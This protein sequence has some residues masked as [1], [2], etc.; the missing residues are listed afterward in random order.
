M[1]QAAILK[2]GEVVKLT[3]LINPK[4]TI[5][6]FLNSFE[7]V[8]NG[9]T[10]IYKETLKEDFRDDD[11]FGQ[12]DK[13]VIGG[14]YEQDFFLEYLTDKNKLNQLKDHKYPF[15]S[16]SVNDEIIVK[17]LKVLSP[18]TDFCKIETYKWTYQPNIPIVDYGTWQIKI[19]N[20][21]FPNPPE[22]VNTQLNPTAMQFYSHKIGLFVTPLTDQNDKQAKAFLFAKIGIL[23]NSIERI[24]NLIE[25]DTNS[26]FGQYINSQKSEWSTQPIFTNPTVAVLEDYMRILTNFYNSFYINQI[27]IKKAPNKEKFY[28]LARCLSAEALS[29]VPTNDKIELL[30]NISGFSH[31]LTESNNG[32]QLA[33]KIIESFTFNSVTAAER[34]DLLYALMQIQVYQVPNSYKKT[35][36]FDTKQTLFE[37]L[38]S[39]IDDDRISRYTVGP[40]EYIAG[41]LKTNDNRKK[42]IL[43][44]Y[45]I[46][47]SSMYNPKYADPS[48]SSP[49]NIFGI[50]PESYYMK[51]IPENDNSSS[52]SAFYN[53]ETSPAILVYNA[54]TSSSTDHYMRTTGVE[55]ILGDLEGKK[56]KIHQKQT[57]SIIENSSKENNQHISTFTSL[58]GTYDLYQPISIIGFRP[59]LDLVETFEDPETGVNLNDPFPNIPVFF[60]YYMQDYSD[61]KKLDFGIVLVAE[62]AL[63]LTG[64]G[65]LN[66]LKY[67]GYLSKARSVWTGT[68]TASETVLFW[69]AVEGVNATVQFTA[70]N[71]SAI[72]NYSNNT[73]TDPDIKEFTNK[74]SVLFDI[75]TIVSLGTDP[76]MKKKLTNAAAEVV[77]QEAKLIT[78]GKSHGLSTD[79]MNAIKSIC[80]VETLTD[81]MDLKIN[82]LPT[83]ANDNILVKYSTFT[84]EEKYD[85]FTSFYNINKEADW[86]KMNIQHTRI[87][88]GAPKQYTLV[89]IWRNEIKYLKNQRTIEVLEGFHIIIN[90]S[91]L[92]EHIHKGHGG[93]SSGKPWATGAHNLDLLDGVRW[94]WADESLVLTDSKGYKYGKIQRNMSDMGWTGGRPPTPWKT[95]TDET[96][97]WKKYSNDPSENIQRINEEMSL[98][99][100]N[101]KF[102]R[103]QYNRDGITIKSDIFH[104][105]A[106]DGKEIEI[107]LKHGTNQIISIYPTFTK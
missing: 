23:I 68:A 83:Y 14:F 7:V 21:V 1:E 78:R 10:K 97:F 52:S 26:D 29:M 71:L 58:Y 40:L 30:K 64:V 70:D 37:I 75:L 60:L 101:K 4:Y 3:G 46:W 62:V 31:Y 19:P 20:G 66:D 99:F 54:S 15:K 32:E 103:F 12:I 38:Y 61:L 79:T 105:F 82:N 41:F 42:F 2:S 22:G 56:I 88:N 94:R 91:K 51:L 27:L 73:T 48:Y 95:K 28:W 53:P 36:T 57:T 11:L 63:N 86:T 43:L 16:A 13:D 92:L 17:K 18:Y 104:G 50:Y 76:I 106:S 65:A 47:K 77:A 44:L 45:K 25:L 67:L 85:F 72:N 80:D 93:L 59:D 84:K 87:L 90:N 102:T 49:A 5:Y 100:A 24:F 74:V 81:L 69:K 35:K 8:I 9:V 55:Y 96:T 34:N 39:K 89:D 107:V 6:G 98:A 33:L